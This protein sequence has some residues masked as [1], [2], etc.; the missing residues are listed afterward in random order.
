MATPQKRKAQKS[1]SKNTRRTADK[2]KK[3]NIQ[4]NAII[5]H[6]W[7]KKQTLI[8]NYKRL[9]LMTSLN[10]KAGG[11]EKLYP[12]AKPEHPSE[13]QEE[14][15]EQEEKELTEED[16]ARLEK[17][18]KPGEGI[19]QRDDEGNVIR[20]IVGRQKTHDEI[21]EEEPEPVEAK[22]DVV[23]QLEEQARNAHKNV[24]YQSMYQQHWVARLITKYGDDYR[25]MFRDEDLN[26]NQLTE[27]QLKKKCSQFLKQN[28]GFERLEQ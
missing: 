18:L 9:G 12:D 19:I 15:E 14:G 27:N 21:L 16:V 24:K 17:S 22:T 23:R 13:D 2:R 6:N 28:P 20:V 10:G 7:D 8:Q 4:G 5:K 25:A 11:V 26:Q 1:G 3:Y